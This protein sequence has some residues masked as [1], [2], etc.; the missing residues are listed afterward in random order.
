MFDA[1]GLAAVKMPVLLIRPEDDA[2]MASG[3]NAL[4]LVENLPFR[5]QDDVVPVRHFIF[6]DPC[7][8]TIAAEAALICSDEPGVDRDRCIGK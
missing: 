3:A 2:Y 8:E 4:A 6:V 1:T 5:P 7:P